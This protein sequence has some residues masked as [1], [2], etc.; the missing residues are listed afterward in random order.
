MANKKYNQFDAG[1]PV[2]TDIT[3]FANPTTGLL[4]KVTIDDLLSVG[5]AGAGIIQRVKITKTFAD[6]AAASTTNTIDAG[7]SLP[8]NAWTIGA[9]IVLNTTFSG[10]EI[11]G[12]T[13][14]IGTVAQPNRFLSNPWNLFTGAGQFQGLLNN[15]PPI[16]TS[17]STA[18]KLTATSIDANLNA[19]TQGTAD[20][21][22]Y[23]S[24]LD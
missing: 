20:I 9:P 15:T 12:Y 24:V 10:G 17:V 1:T 11:S 4:K 16:S 18:L 14:E 2:G 19:A 22:I 8:A 13:L 21:W 5:G 7:F 23:Y 3:L 6:F